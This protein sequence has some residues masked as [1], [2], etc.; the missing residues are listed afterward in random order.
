[1]TQRR[2]NVYVRLN[3][4]SL[5]KVGECRLCGEKAYLGDDKGP[6]H[7][8]CLMWAAELA[9]GRPRP[10][11]ASSRTATAKWKQRQAADARRRRRK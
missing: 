8:C 1:M 6:V 2:T 3:M 4:H 10:A 5:G 7:G 9:K 11:C